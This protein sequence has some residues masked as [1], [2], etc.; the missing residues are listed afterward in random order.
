[1]HYTYKECDL[2]PYTDAYEAIESMPIVQ[3]STEYDNPE[4]LE[5]T[6]IILNEA[7]YMVNKTEYKL[8]K[9]NQ[10]RYYIITIQDNPLFNASVLISTKKH[11]L[12][13]LLMIKGTVIR[14]ATRTLTD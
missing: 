10:I 3:V 5:T 13:M 8:V 14:V 2:S 9:P 11:E 1:M 12:P 4:T 7:I 6:I